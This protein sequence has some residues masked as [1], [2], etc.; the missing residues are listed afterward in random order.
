MPSVFDDQIAR[1]D[2]SDSRLFVGDSGLNEPARQNF[3]TSI[4]Q[5][6]NT[7]QQS[8]EHTLDQ[9]K[10]S[11]PAE[12]RR[13]ILDRANAL[14]GVTVRNPWDLSDDLFTPSPIWPDTMK[15]I[16]AIRHESE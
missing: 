5:E 12:Y 13:I 7:T 9:F 6:T 15:K 10:L 16:A 3:R 8:I 1:I 11:N 2:Q 4:N 14:L